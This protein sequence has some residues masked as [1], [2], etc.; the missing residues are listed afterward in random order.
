MANSAVGSVGSMRGE[1]FGVL[2]RAHFGGHQPLGADAKPRKKAVARLDVGEAIT[3]QRLHMYEYVFGAFAPRQ[4]AKA[5]H[6]VEPFDDDDLEAAR[7]RHLDMRAGRR[8]L[9][10]MGSIARLYGNHMKDLHALVALD[11]FGHHARAFM[12]SLEPVAPQHGDVNEHI[13]LA[14]VGNDEA[15]AFGHVEPFDIAGDF[16]KSERPFE[17]RLRGVAADF[18]TQLCIVVA[19]L[20]RPPPER[21]INPRSGPHHKAQSERDSDRPVARYFPLCDSAHRPATPQAKLKSSD[22]SPRVSKI[23]PVRRK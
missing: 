6:P 5:A 2:Q 3:A 18:M 11:R 7:R 8:Q 17:G 21:R 22:N 4:E 13:R 1:D 9:R 14:A 23:A 16:D 12:Q 20:S 15:V 19:H 10:S